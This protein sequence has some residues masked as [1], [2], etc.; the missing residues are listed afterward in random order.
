MTSPTDYDYLAT[1][2]DQYS[3]EVGEA[4]PGETRPRRHYLLGD[5][6][7]VNGAEFFNSQN[8]WEGFLG[9]EK[10]SN[11]GT[12]LG[13]RAKNA[14]GT[15]GDFVWQSY[16][17]IR[18]RALNV[19]H[20]L[21][22]LGLTTQGFV[23]LYSVN[24]L[25]WTLGELGSY[26]KN[27]CTVPLYD[28]LGDESIVFIINQTEMT[29]VFATCDK[30]ANL[31]RLK[32]RIPTLKT[33]ILMDAPPTGDTPYY[34]DEA[35]RAACVFAPADLA[36]KARTDL[37]EAG[38]EVYAH[39]DLEKLGSENPSD[40]VAA[41]PDD[42][43]TICY[44][45]GTTGL[46]KGVMLTHN[47]ILSDGAGFMYLGDRGESIIINSSSYYLSFLP[48]AHVFER[49]VFQV[50]LL[51]G[52]TIGFYQG[53]IRT[54]MDDIAAL[55]PTIFVAVPRLLNRVYDR[56]RATIDASPFLSK[57]LFDTA[58][59]T[60]LA[61]VASG[62]RTHWLWDRLVFSKVRERLGGRVQYILSGSAPVSAEILQFLRVCF[63]CYVFEGYGQTETTAGATLTC[64]SD[65]SSGHT[66][67]PMPNIEVKLVD[68][69]EMNYFSTDKP[70]PR[71]EVCLRGY[72]ITHGY[73]KD[74]EKTRTCAA[75]PC[76]L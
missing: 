4:R 73:Y 20:A 57:F 19:G 45:S 46:P 42:L 56:I 34:P 52:A 60:K 7:L 41:T 58:Y 15:A 6:P 36:T 10:A 37:T 31:L 16:A 65:F 70:F 23:G 55:R 28:T 76:P 50:L 13:V 67:P 74:E 39:L 62:S 12:C 32:E 63:S 51:R 9:G 71:G 8:L 72:S 24:R 14:D 47:N 54:L 25:E 40:L 26:T 5:K 75:R 17:Q 21:T 1:P 22:H 68:V 2:P 61:N 69:P 43:A 29:L 44:T 53:D 66:G 11:G 35:A 64:K 27:L 38:F 48:L 33:I 18:A 30:A 49:V 3:V 59:N